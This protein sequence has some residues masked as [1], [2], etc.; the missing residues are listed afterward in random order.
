MERGPGTEHT[1]VWWARRD[2]PPEPW[3]SAPAQFVEDQTCDL[4]V[5]GAG[6]TGL[7]T[8][9]LLARRGV[10]PLV[11]EARH[12]AA[13]TTGHSTAK[14]SL[15]QGATYSGIAAHTDAET[16]AAYA[17]A[18]AAGQRWL[19]DFCTESDVDVQRRDAWTYAVTSSGAQ[20]VQREAQAC[21]LAG[22]AVEQS[23]STELPFDVEAALRLPDQAQLDPVGLCLALRAEVEVL[24]GRVVEGVRVTGMNVGGSPHD[25]G[26]SSSGV[27]ASGGA[28][29]TG[30][31]D[32]SPLTEDDVDVEAPDRGRPA[33]DGER[34][35]TLRTSAGEV[36][37]RRVVVAT[38]MPVL[39]RALYFARLQ[40]QRSYALA[41]R[42]PDP[43]TLPRGMYLS[44]DNPT[45]SLRTAPDGDR[46]LLLVGGDNHVVGRSA[47]PRAAVE[48]LDSWTRAH[49][50]GAVRV[51]TW[52]A[53]DYESAGKLPIVGTMPRTHGSVL[54]AT[55][56]NKWG[57]TNAAAAALILVGKLL[58]DDADELPWARHL[59]R[60]TPSPRDLL[61]GL[62]FNASVGERLTRDWALRALPGRSGAAPHEGQGWVERGSIHPTA[63]CTVAGTTHRVEG[64][65][66]HLGGI[67]SW[68]DSDLSWDC[69]LHGSRFTADG[70][71]LEGPAVRDLESR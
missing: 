6:L 29:A 62:T 56:F 38:G 63:T 34:V 25:T 36:R 10:R 68:N 59:Q 23:T 28:D 15:L 33:G 45:R 30:I 48:D 8:A 55:G 66:P 13:G 27:L 31:P 11:L 60:R 35:V 17:A 32:G 22:L 70:H 14:V 7:C 47:S 4:V 2:Q 58:G 21:A 57:M 52:A 1:S 65:C 40:P 5:V 18:Q 39:D 67:L 61:S 12:V 24:G 71:C 43:A 16:A 46:E 53:Q 50:P 64:V 54:V 44:L 20:R 41:F 3:E 19:L 37:A 69:P 51:H 9:V 49:F 42:L 26:P